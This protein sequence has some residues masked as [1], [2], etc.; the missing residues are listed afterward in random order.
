M[1][2]SN[3]DSNLS[4][5]DIALIWATAS[6]RMIEKAR[7]EVTA[8]VSGADPRSVF[9]RVE[10]TNIIENNIRPIILKDYCFS[11]NQDI[12]EMGIKLLERNI[13]KHNIV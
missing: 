6:K 8:F 3:N 7:G 1:D 10:L 2:L 9:C 11:E 13:G 12:H 4:N 5:D